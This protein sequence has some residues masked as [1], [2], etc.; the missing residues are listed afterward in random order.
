MPGCCTG[1]VRFGGGGSPS[2]LSSARISGIPGRIEL[3]TAVSFQEPEVSDVEGF[4]VDGNKLLDVC[5]NEFVMR[6]VNMAYTWYKSSAYDQL[7]AIRNHG[8]NAV[9]IVLTD[10]KD[11]GTPA[12]E[13]SAVKR[14]IEACRELGMVTILEV[15]DETGSDNLV[16]LEQ[17]RY[18]QR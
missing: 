13:A 16:E 4:H 7:K 9:R 3:D 6:G 2:L 17:H 5:D 10:G 1:R 8:A 14:L 11:Y 12:D 18:Q 15:H